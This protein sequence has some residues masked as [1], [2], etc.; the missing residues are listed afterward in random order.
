MYICFWYNSINNHIQGVQIKLCFPNKFHNFAI[1]P[2]PQLGCYWLYRKWSANRSTCTLRSLARMSCSP[3]FRGGVVVLGKFFCTPCMYIHC[4]IIG[5][6][7]Y[8]NRS[9]I[10]CNASLR[11]THYPQ[12]Q[13]WWRPMKEKRFCLSTY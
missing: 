5:G 2:T 4:G 11:Y 9:V 13:T 1:S 12:C 6:A 8:C 7:I 3:L 10:E